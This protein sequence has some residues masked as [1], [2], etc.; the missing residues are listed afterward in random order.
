MN[1]SLRGG[2]IEDGGREVCVT[3]VMWRDPSLQAKWHFM[4]WGTSSSMQTAEYLGVPWF[5]SVSPPVHR[6]VQRAQDVART[7]GGGV[8][9]AAAST[10]A[11]PTRSHNP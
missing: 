2:W 4:D 3:L 10:T 8:E 11:A 6:L 1:S 9:S 7:G 5:T